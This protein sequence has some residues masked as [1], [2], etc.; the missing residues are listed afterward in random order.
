MF[1]QDGSVHAVRGQIHRGTQAILRFSPRGIRGEYL[2][3]T[4]VRLS[5]SAVRGQ[6]YRGTQAIL[7]TFPIDKGGMNFKAEIRY[8]MVGRSSIFRSS[9]E[10][11]RNFMKKK[12]LT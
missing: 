7:G 9:L 12:L 2:Q 10:D 8:F 3:A 1:Y 4:A 5:V 11:R 6:T